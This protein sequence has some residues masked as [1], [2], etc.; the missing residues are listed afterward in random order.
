MNPEP[1][2]SKRTLWLLT[3][4]VLCILV[5]AVLLFLNV[6]PFAART[7][8][9]NVTSLTY[10]CYDYTVLCGYRIETAE[11]G[12]VWFDDEVKGAGYS[13]RMSQQDLD[14]LRRVV[15]DSGIYTW[16]GYAGRSARSDDYSFHLRIDFDSG[17]CL[18]AYG[19]GKTPKGYEEGH[20]ALT[21][22]FEALTSRCMPAS[23]EL[24]YASF[25]FEGLAPY[26]SFVFHDSG[27][28]TSLESRARDGSSPVL[29]V[30]APYT[31]D[32]FS[33]PL[34]QVIDEYG[35]AD[36]K[37]HLSENPDLSGSLRVVLE[38]GGDSV[39]INADGLYPDNY[40]AARD[41]VSAFFLKYCRENP[42]K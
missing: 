33:E 15:E 13:M 21:A 18:E 39:Y 14:L 22:Y 29:T 40:L 23:H 24:L 5:I 4:A 38:Y 1:V 31:E 36:W 37:G 41:A 42:D 9:G 6:Y 8:G 10:R 20:E 11:D 2:R 17:D 19:N 28:E 7:T 25:Y 30:T 12:N 35:V 16:N 32:R 26:D 34:R 27:R 3:C